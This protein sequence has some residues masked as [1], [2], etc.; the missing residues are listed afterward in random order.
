MSFLKDFNIAFANGNVNF[1]SENVSDNIIWN[2]VSEKKITGKESF[3]KEIKM[4]K[5]IKISEIILDQIITH[6]S[7][8]AVSG[9]M[10][11]ENGEKYAFSD[12]YKFSS[13]KGLIIKEI[14]SFAIKI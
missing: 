5:N 8:G 7:G 6:G 9:I 2:I 14:N 11:L 3:E 1:L 13:S 10:K 12:F 4:M